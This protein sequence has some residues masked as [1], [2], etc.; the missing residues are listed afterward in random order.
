[1]EE[2]RNQILRRN[3]GQLPGNRLGA[4]TVVV[5]NAS[6]CAVTSSAVTVAVNNAPLASVAAASSTTFCTGKSVLLKAITGA[7]YTYQW[8]KNSVSIVGETTSNYTATTAGNY[9]V[10]VSN[11]NGCSTTSSVIMVATTPAP[12]ASVAITAPLTFCEGG[13]V[14]LKGVVGTG[15]TYQWKKNGVNIPAQTQSNYTANASGVYTVLVTN[16][17]SCTTLSTGI[18]VTVTPAPATTITANGPLTFPQGGSVTLNVPVT[19]GNTYQWKKDAVNITG[20]TTASY[21]A[22]TSGN[23]TVAVTNPGG[24]QAISLPAV[25]TVTQ[26]RPITKGL[27]EDE[28]ITV[29][30]NPLYRNNYLNIDWRIAGDNAVFVTVYDMS[31]KKINSQRL[32][33]G[34]RAIKITGASGLY[35]VE[36]RW[37]INKRKVFKV[38]KIE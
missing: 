22:T 3:T 8:K 4:Y 16:A 13:S 10:V 18:N 27:Q 15:Y 2:S 20:A 14:L 33:A 38:V 21:A 34:D 7:G 31:G 23:Y 12:L 28:N 17:Q 25:V 6:G 26:S 35:L 24:C 37:G 32:L 30:P 1:M 29:Y 19:A 5:T 9:S 11:A 36:C